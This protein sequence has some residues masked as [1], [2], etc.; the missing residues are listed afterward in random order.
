MSKKRTVDEETTSLKFDDDGVNEDEF[1]TE[2][3]REIIREEDDGMK[4]VPYTTGDLE[5]LIVDLEKQLQKIRCYQKA[6]R[7]QLCLD[8]G[9]CVLQIVQVSNC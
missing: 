2:E 4:V 6:E 7:E 9:E 8:L 5:E 3:L 1:A